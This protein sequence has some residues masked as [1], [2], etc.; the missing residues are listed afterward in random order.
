MSECP[1]GKVPYPDVASTRPYQRGDRGNRR[2][3]RCRYC[4]AYHLTTLSRAQLRRARR[5]P[6]PRQFANEGD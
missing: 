6:T 2:P 4:D 1:T 3:Y 5:K